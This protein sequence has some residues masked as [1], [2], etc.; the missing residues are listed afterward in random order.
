MRHVK[1]YYTPAT[2][3]E[4]VTLLQQHHGHARCIA[5]GTHVAT[6]KDPTIEYLVDITSCGIQTIQEHNDYLS[7]GACVTL[8]DLNQSDLVQQYANGILCDV[9]RWTGSVQR[10][11]SAT[12]GGSLVLQQ[13]LALPLLSL[14]AQ[15]LLMGDGERI[16]P[17]NDFYADAKLHAAEIITECRIPIMSKQARGAVRRQSRTRQDV[18]IAAAAV[19]VTVTENICQRA[20]IT[21]APVKT[22]IC[23]VPAA[24]QCLQGHPLT[25]ETI[26]WAADTLTQTV[27]PVDDHRASA[28][29]RRKVLGI[30]LKRALMQL[31]GEL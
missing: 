15:L 27:Q 23:R 10:R 16:V 21:A 8:E 20:A 12:I 25:S 19:V 30:Y 22:G 26:E 3:Q 11:N 5:G 14:N 24:E 6:L 13:D 2:V 28:D 31:E 7:L 4:A 18:S 9:A 17:L 1:E 29:Y